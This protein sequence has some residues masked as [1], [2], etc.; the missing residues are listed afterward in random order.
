[1]RDT[2]QGLELTEIP[3]SFYNPAGLTDKSMGTDAYVRYYWH[4]V[5]DLK[6]INAYNLV[7]REGTLMSPAKLSG[8]VVPGSTTRELLEKLSEESSFEFLMLE[9]EVAETLYV[10]T[11]HHLLIYVQDTFMKLALLGHIDILGKGKVEAG[12]P[13]NPAW[14]QSL[15]DRVD[16]SARRGF[17]SMLKEL[18]GFGVN[19][20]VE[21]DQIKDVLRI[22]QERNLLVHHHGIIHN[23]YLSKYPNSGKRVGERLKPTLNEVSTVANTILAFVGKVDVQMSAEYDLPTT[24][25]KEYSAKLCQERLNEMLGPAFEALR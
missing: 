12:A 2:V 22:N 4:M 14:K 1:M 17:E 5:R 8:L 19:L 9:D 24:S 21:N 13:V 23:R 20:S 15:R 18:Q 11:V 7:L 10:R 16:K 25:T 6:F 3:E